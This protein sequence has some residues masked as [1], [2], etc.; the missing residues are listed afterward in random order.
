MSKIEPERTVG[1]TA[2]LP[3]SRGKSAALFAGVFI[4]FFSIVISL[5]IAE[6]GFRIANGV[7][8]LDT[9]NW[10][11]DGVR[12]KRIGDRAIADAKL[13]WTLK[14]GYR[15]EGFDTIDHG[16]RQNF[17]EERMRPNGILAVGD[18]FTEGFDEVV[19]A[20]TWP[21]HLEKKLA[22]PV[23]NGGVAGYATDQIILRAEELLPI[24]QPKTLIIGF[25]EVDISRAALSDAGAPKPYFTVENNELIYHPPGP[26]D[27]KVEESSFGS[28]VRGVL[29]YS[30]LANH[31]ISRLAPKFWYPTEASVYTEVENDAL[32]VTCR[33]LDRLKR[34]TSDKKIRLLLFLQYG[35]ELVLEEPAIVEDMRGVTDCAQKLG[36]QIVDQFAPLKAL[37]NGNPDKVAEYFVLHGEEF[38]HMSSKGNEH[39]AQLLAD[40][41]RN[42]ESPSDGA[43][44]NGNVKPLQN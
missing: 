14:T 23:I 5:L 25:T 10:R 3:G 4:A 34:Q 16:I 26:L 1:D 30:F 43:A 8:L 24:V 13:G 32:D 42:E 11:L 21:A 12:T 40:A 36:I 19:D 2:A 35:G 29:G 38:G 6:A 39:A 20:A 15:S 18:S 28:A 41:I 31:L 7:S 44:Q 17:D 33:L 27:P 22:V 37:T 9:Q